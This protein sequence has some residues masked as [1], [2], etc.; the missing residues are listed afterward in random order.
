[1][2]DADFSTWGDHL[3][4]RSNRGEKKKAPFGRKGGRHSGRP[5]GL[6]KAECVGHQ[7]VGEKPAVMD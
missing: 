7:A 3:P 4:G 1:M 5:G 2:A 6:P